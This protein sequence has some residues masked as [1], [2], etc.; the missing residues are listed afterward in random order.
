LF[1][2]FS[3]WPFQEKKIFTKKESMYPSKLEAPLMKKLL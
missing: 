1:N 3:F 2:L